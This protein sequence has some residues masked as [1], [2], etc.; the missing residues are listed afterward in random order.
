[1]FTPNTLARVYLENSQGKRKLVLEVFVLKSTTPLASFEVVPGTLEGLPWTQSSV[2]K[3]L[4]LRNGLQSWCHGTDGLWSP[5][6]L[7]GIVHNTQLFL[8][9]CELSGYP[10]FPQTWPRFF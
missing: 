1:M 2:A 4:F 8:S 6:L 3:T 9:L 7:L 5:N 10:V